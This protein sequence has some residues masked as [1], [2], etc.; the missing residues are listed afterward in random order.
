MYL[1]THMHVYL[2][3]IYLKPDLFQKLAIGT[4]SSLSNEKALSNTF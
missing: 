3:Y 2:L 1:D 4:F